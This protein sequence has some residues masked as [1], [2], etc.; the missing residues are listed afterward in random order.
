MELLRGLDGLRDRHRPCVATIGAFDGVHLGHRAVIDQLAEQGARFD[1]PTTVVTFEPLPREFL[2]GDRAPARIQSFRDKIEAL[3]AL[4][5]DRLLCLRFNDALRGMSADRFAR[6]LFVDGLA[7]R[8]LVLGDDFRF[9]K[10]RE[11][12]AAFMR[13]LGEEEGFETLA[14]R[15]VL[16]DDERVSSTRLRAALGEGD[17]VL[18]ERL[19]GRP[20]TLSGR[21]MHG[22]RLG[23][24]L[25]APT[26]NVG[27]R[28]RSVPLRGVY[29]VRVT[30]SDR[31]AGLAN[32]PAIANVGTRP[33]I[34]QGQRANLEV[35]VLDGD[36][37]L[38]GRRLSV[39]FEHKLRDETRFDSVE[40]LKA[41]IHADIAAAREWFVL[42]AGAKRS[43]A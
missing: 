36:H 31:E 11:G 33:T 5:V 43:E 35:H 9:G 16:I 41:R 20:F 7:V 38:Y 25:G 39:Q 32:T 15:T 10:A 1:L 8:A 26:A 40:A 24:E 28:R 27:L 6:E 21:V 4:G 2:A 22:R 12:D 19:L 34:E 29:A 42:P 3:R 30:C 37:A 14:T 23:R 18:A 17:F 13:S